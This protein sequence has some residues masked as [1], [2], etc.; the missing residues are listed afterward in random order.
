MATLPASGHFIKIARCSDGF[1]VSVGSSMITP[2]RG[3]TTPSGTT[4]SGVHSFR[5]LVRQARSASPGAR[6]D[7]QETLT[8]LAFQKLVTRKDVKNHR[9]SPVSVERLQKARALS[10]G[11]YFFFARGRY[12]RPMVV[13]GVLLMG[14]IMIRCQKTGQAI[15]TGRNVEPATFRSSPV[16]FSRT[17]CPLCRSMHEWFARDA[18]VRETNGLECETMR[19]G[20]VALDRMRKFLPIALVLRRSLLPTPRLHASE[21]SITRCR[22]NRDYFTCKR[23]CKEALA[24]WPGHTTGARSQIA[25]TDGR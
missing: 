7:V 13:E 2:L 23:T 19:E 20:Q 18:W 17:Y 9:V 6:N 4:V 3:D 16:F 22:M 25:P 5:S 14:M 8:G 12:V 21:P 24:I 15:S 11:F 1:A 10:L